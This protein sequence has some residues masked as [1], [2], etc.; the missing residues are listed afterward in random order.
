MSRP[1]PLM[2]LIE[3]LQRLPADAREI[4]RGANDCYRSRIHKAREIVVL[5]R[6]RVD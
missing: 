4:V 2:K 1:D 5:A 6:R 3:Q